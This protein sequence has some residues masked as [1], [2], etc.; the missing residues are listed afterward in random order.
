MAKPQDPRKLWEVDLGQGKEAQVRAATVRDVR[1]ERLVYQTYDQAE[2]PSGGPS[3]GFAAGVWRSFR[4]VE[5]AE[6]RDDR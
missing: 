1:G 6:P 2:E 4:H 5:D 3:D